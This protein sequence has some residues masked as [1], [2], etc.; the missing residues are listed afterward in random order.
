M[1]KYIAK[2]RH[3][4]TAFV[5][6]LLLGGMIYFGAKVNRL[7]DVHLQK[8]SY[9]GSA[10]GT[11]V[12]K[13]IYVDNTSQSQQINRQI[14][15]CLTE[16]EEQISV[17]VT[18]SAVSKC[19]ANYVAGDVF[20]IS[21]NILEYLGQEI[22]IS[23][24]TGG[25]YSPCIRP[26]ASLW[27]IEDGN[28]LIPDDEVIKE[29]L[30]AVNVDNVEITDNGV[31]LHAENM[32]IDFGAS[33][34]GIACDEVAKLLAGSDIQGAVI[35]IGGSILVYGDK[36]D[37]RNW[38][39]GI[40]DPR[41]ETG[42]VLGILEVEGGKVVSTSG[43]YEKYFEQD[44]KRYHHILDPHTGYP[45]ES[46]LI[47]VTIIS[48]S[49]FLSDTMSTACFVMGLEDGMAYAEEKGVEAVF[50]TEEKEVHVTSGIKKWFRL[51]TNDYDL[52]K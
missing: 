29:T 33:G 5:V 37:G 49:G 42:E 3:M 23:K 28:T 11:V 27:G 46:G 34:K 39:V 47:S 13:S 24:E 52:V 7:K 38:H 8:G 50:I 31:I 35:A 36:G 15:E 45:A 16:L 22:Q 30:E 2:H 10:M 1:I 43:D 44:G 4:I 18:D 19:N 51:Q 12:K 48:D 40:Q 14:D 41:A 20:A 26:L 6:I 25:A 9:T 32:S 21:P 17:R